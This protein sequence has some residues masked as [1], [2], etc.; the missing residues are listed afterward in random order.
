MKCH[1][2]D[3]GN[4]PLAPLQIFSEVPLMIGNDY[5]DRICHQFENIN[6]YET[7]NRFIFM[8]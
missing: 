7:K 3:K 6:Y 2:I 5:R 4:I 8:C 1:S